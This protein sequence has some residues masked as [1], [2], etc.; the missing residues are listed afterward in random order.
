[1]KK[2]GKKLKLIIGDDNTPIDVTT[3]SET[4][5]EIEYNKESKNWKQ[6]VSKPKS[7]TIEFGNQVATGL[8]SYFELQSIVEEEIQKAF[9]AIDRRI[10]EKGGNV[11][12]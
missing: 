10:E 8:I 6:V 9:K 2:N 11:S 3:L 5:V 7:I 12:L 1:M 4:P